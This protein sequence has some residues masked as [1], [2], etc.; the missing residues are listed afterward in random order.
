MVKSLVD[1]FNANGKNHSECTV[2]KQPDSESL[3]VD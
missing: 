1:I 3:T 2:E